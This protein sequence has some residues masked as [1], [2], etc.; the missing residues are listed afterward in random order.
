MM[1][2]RRR[3][4]VWTHVIGLG[5]LLGAIGGHALAQNQETAARRVAPTSGTTA[6][7]GLPLPPKVGS[8]PAVVG[9][10]RSTPSDAAAGRAAVS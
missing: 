7:F 8:I 2:S 5:C 6:W 3:L 1:H 9:R 4:P 10:A